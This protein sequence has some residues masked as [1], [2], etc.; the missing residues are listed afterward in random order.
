MRMRHIIIGSCAWGLLMLFGCA[1]EAPENNG[2]QHTHELRLSLGSH[3]YDMTRS[4]GEMPDGF[5]LHNQ[6]TASAKIMQ[7]QGYLTFWNTDEPAKWDFVPTAFIYEEPEG[8]SVG[9]HLWTS[10]VPLKTLGDGT[11]YY[12]YGFLPK[13]VVL[14]TVTILPYDGTESQENGYAK[15]AKLTFNDLDAVLPKDICVIV[16]AK[17]YGKE[18]NTD[19]P[20]MKTPSRLGVFTYNPDTEGDNIFLL[21][22]H[23]Y[24]GIR[25]NI[26]LDADYS[27]LRKI[28]VTNVKLMPIGDNS[29]E[30]VTVNVNIVANKEGQDPIAT[31]GGNVTY[32]CKKGTTPKPAIFEGELELTTAFQPFFGYVCPADKKVVGNRKFTL[33]TTYDVYDTENVKIREGETASNTITLRDDL[34]LVAGSIHTVNITV[35]PTYLYVLSNPDLDNPTFVVNN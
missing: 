35:L 6:A 1:D 31:S 32:T 24:A 22:E 27:K 19:V 28:K 3:Q 21:V 14:N 2:Q 5:T 11:F 18:G 13:E 33:V 20:N 12:L 7:I 25:F 16:G 34:N 8:P 15:G 10:T 4:A 23:L 26:K 17:G 30:K 29:V 9:N